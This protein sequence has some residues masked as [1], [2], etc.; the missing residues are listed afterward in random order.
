MTSN[1][2]AEPSFKPASVINAIMQPRSVAIVGISS[3]PG[4]AGR[5]VLELLGNNKFE[6]PIFLVGRS[7]NI[8]GRKVHA[9][10]DELPENVDL[11]VLTLPAAAVRVAVEGCVRRK[12]RAAIIFASGFAEVSDDGVSEQDR[13]GEIAR[14]GGL[15]LVGPN[16]LGLMNFVHGFAAVFFSPQ[17]I[18]RL[19]EGT[20]GAVAVVAQ[21]GGLGSHLQSGLTARGVPVSSGN[22]PNDMPDRRSTSNDVIMSTTDR[23]S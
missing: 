12:V 11:A 4:S 22:M 3:K 14:A 6:G 16:C 7:S 9:S 13:I 17:P 18:P 10:V 2:P 20:R 21:S 15:G 5:V 23:T 19:P 8:D 1:V